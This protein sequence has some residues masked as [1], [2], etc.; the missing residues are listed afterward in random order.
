[1][2]LVRTIFSR[3]SDLPL[4]RDSL[5]KFLP[6]L[7]AFM[8]FLAVL[9]LAGLLVLNTLAHRWDKGISNS[10][11]VQVPFSGDAIRDA[12]NLKTAVRITRG[13]LGVRRAEPIPEKRIA[14]LLEPWLGPVGA[15]SAVPLPSLIEVEVENGATFDTE[16]LGQRL[17]AKVPG[18]TV[19]SHRVWLDRLLNL[20]GTVRGLAAAILLFIALATVGTVVFTTRTGLAIHQD[21]IEVLHLIGAKDN[22]VAGQFAVRALWL[23]LRGGLIGLILAVP[24]LWM[25]GSLFGG[26]E[27]GLIP[28]VA[29]EAFHWMVLAAL[30]LL[31][32]VIAMVTA[33]MTV[34]RS[35]GRML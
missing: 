35:L 7:I 25:I 30:P 15:T 19:D 26:V 24:T 34:M 20:I 11:T 16:A 28:K 8:V 21:V 18:A 2:A 3:R 23:G 27:D 1:M 14:E 33:R 13:A 9:A 31:V 22:Y 5:S 6:W 29:M 12:K 10:L 17:N 32:A 4:D